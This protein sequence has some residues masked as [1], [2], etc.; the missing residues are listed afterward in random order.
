LT[1]FAEIGSIPPNFRGRGLGRISSP[2]AAATFSMP[3]LNLQ[4]SFTLDDTNRGNNT[5]PLTPGGLYAQQRSTQPASVMQVGSRGRG[6]AHVTGKSAEGYLVGLLAEPDPCHREGRCSR[7]LVRPKGKTAGIR[8]GWE[9][10]RLGRVAGHTGF[11]DS[12]SSANVGIDNKA[13]GQRRL[14][15]TSARTW[16]YSTMAAMAILCQGP[17]QG[18]GLVR[19]TRQRLNSALTRSAAV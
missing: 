17:C 6:R 14:R 4:F 12:Y 8:G 11:E 5:S 18:Q 16:P 13:A 15:S 1:R 7:S 2:L 9:S 3:H 10:T 19:L